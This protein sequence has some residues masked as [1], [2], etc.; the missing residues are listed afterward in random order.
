MGNPNTYYE[1]PT[2]C[3]LAGALAHL[4]QH[5]ENGCVRSAYLA[6][7]LLEQIV[8]DPRADTHLRQHAQQLVEI[9]ERDPIHS[10]TSDVSQGSHPA[11]AH[12]QAIARR[13][14]MQ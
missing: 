5:I 11:F 14:S 8:A 12:S 9:L 10:P 2:T 1:Q 13:K 7:M 6:A 3:I 4:A